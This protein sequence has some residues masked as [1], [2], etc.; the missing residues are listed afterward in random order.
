MS[1]NYVRE[2]VSRDCVERLLQA[3][4]RAWGQRKNRG[5]TSAGVLVVSWC[6]AS[7][8]CVASL[9]RDAVSGEYNGRHSVARMC[10]RAA[11]RYGVKGLG[12]RAGPG[13]H[14]KSLCRECVERLCRMIVSRDALGCCVAGV[15]QVLFNCCRHCSGK[16]RI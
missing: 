1:R 10:R 8:E 16:D 3:T 9:C 12:K 7:R 14:V 4:I 6:C 5:T 13:D 11:S 15:C 2:I